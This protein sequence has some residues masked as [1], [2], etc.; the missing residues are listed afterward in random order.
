MPSSTSRSSALGILIVVGDDSFIVAERVDGGDRVFAAVSPAL[1]L[2]RSS[3]LSKPPVVHP[4]S[5]RLRD[6]TGNCPNVPDKIVAIKDFDAKG[7]RLSR[8]LLKRTTDR[9]L[10]FQKEVI[11]G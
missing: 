2:C 7:D 5:H 6:I 3:P 8:L 1:R 10:E 11:N 9:E 4:H